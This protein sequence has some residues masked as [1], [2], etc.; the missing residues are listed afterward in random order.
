MAAPRP[1]EL[2][3]PSKGVWLCAAVFAVAL[4]AGIGGLVLSHL[5]QQADETELGAPGLAIGI[6]LASPLLTPSELPPGLE[7]EA[8][9]ASQAT[10]ERR[11]TTEQAELPKETPVESEQPDRLVTLNDAKAPTEE[12]PEVAVQE[13]APSEQSVA[14]E[15]TAPPSV[16]TPTEAPQS[17][18]VDQGT[19]KS[20]QRARITWQRELQAHLDRHL[21]YPGK[22]PP[23]DAEVIVD[24]VLD[25]TGHVVS[26]SVAQSSGDA[27]FDEAALAMAQR[28][29]PVPA[30]PPLVADEG[31]S[32]RLPVNFTRGRRS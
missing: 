4:H 8:S 30:P 14:Q 16:E 15:A 7:S 25:R 2:P 12:A 23:R 27:A 31:L 21:R 29:N 1:F 5:E 10:A 6:E 20:R 19:G 26:V 11:P 17:V 13:V 32:F 22:S 3:P 9:M 18:T 24:L 28:A